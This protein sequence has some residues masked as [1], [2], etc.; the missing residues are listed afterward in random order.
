M[1]KHWVRTGRTGKQFFKTRLGT[2]TIGEFVLGHTNDHKGEGEQ[3]LLYTPRPLFLKTLP[4]H[5]M[6]DKSY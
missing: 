2:Q 6:T 4:S 1:N 3:I 5:F